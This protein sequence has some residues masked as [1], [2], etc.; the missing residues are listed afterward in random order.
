[1]YS[2]K[3]FVTRK[4]VKSVTKVKQTRYGCFTAIKEILILHRDSKFILLLA[5]F[6]AFSTVVVGAVP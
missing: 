1:M 6:F 3:I 5:S 2:I 4:L